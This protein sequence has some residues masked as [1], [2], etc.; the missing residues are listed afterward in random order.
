MSTIKPETF[1]LT[2]YDGKNGDGEPVLVYEGSADDWSNCF[3]VHPSGFDGNYT[4]R[5]E[6]YL[7]HVVAKQLAE[8]SETLTGYETII[9]YGNTMQIKHP[10][11]VHTVCTFK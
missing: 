3:I 9:K 8:Y 2:I 11:T 10:F 1:V 4:L 5:L 6:D 7:Q